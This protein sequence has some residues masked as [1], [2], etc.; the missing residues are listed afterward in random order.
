MESVCVKKLEKGS[1]LVEI[2]V[3]IVIIAVFSVIVVADFP[4]I[5]KQMA[6]SRAAYDLSQ[7]I[8]RT[9]DFGFSGIRITDSDGSIV[10]VDG[11]GFYIN[12]TADDQQYLIY[13]D[14]DGNGDQKYTP[15]GSGS[16]CDDPITAGYDCII[17]TIN[18]EESTSGVYIKEIGDNVSI[19]SINFTPP[20]PTVTI[21]ANGSSAT[22]IRIVL[23]VVSDD[24]MEKSVFVNSSGLV[25]VE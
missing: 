13:A 2:I 7:T 16:S 20:N 18:M 15:D 14:T 25:Y 12:K 21:T 19:L 23:G 9:E 4:K 3:A 1:T 24:S 17:E 5:K 8:R 10:D 22:S 6:L 11:Y